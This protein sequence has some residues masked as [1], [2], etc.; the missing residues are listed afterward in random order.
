MMYIFSPGQLLD[1]ISTQRVRSKRSF[2]RTSFW[3]AA[4]VPKNAQPRVPSEIPG[5]M[6][7]FL[8]VRLLP[9]LNPPVLLLLVFRKPQMTGGAEFASLFWTRRLESSPA[10]TTGRFADEVGVVR[11]G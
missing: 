5:T 3:F 6:L 4:V 2:S 11:T 10:M 1:W 7:Q 8:T 9:I